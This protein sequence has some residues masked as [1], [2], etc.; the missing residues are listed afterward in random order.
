MSNTK[1]MILAIGVALL[2]G[3]GY[4]LW[5][6]NTQ[7]SV[8]VAMTFIRAETPISR[9]LL[10][11]KPFPRQGVAGSW[12]LHVDRI[13]GK[14]ARVDLF[15]GEPFDERR[16]ANADEIVTARSGAGIVLEPGK[17]AF[18]VPT[19][20]AG[21]VG[22]MVRGGDRVDIIAVPAGANPDESEAHLLLSNVLIIDVRTGAGQQTEGEPPIN[23]V[24]LEVTQEEAKRLA[25]WTAAGQVQLALTPGGEEGAEE[26]PEATPATS[27]KVSPTATPLPLPVGE[28][29]GPGGGEP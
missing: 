18:A 16:L 4:Y 12:I 8:P 13:L 6:S 25:L 3:L 19:T 22:G 7:V 11:L 9:S 2:A 10:A 15:P 29:E 1:R 5:W 24:V 28:R 23:I 20:V 21:A 26:T 14:V 17:V 27:P